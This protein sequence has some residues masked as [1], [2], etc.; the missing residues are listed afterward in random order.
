[1]ILALSADLPAP[2]FLLSLIRLDGVSSGPWYSA[3]IRPPSTLTSIFQYAPD[4]PKITPED[5][6]LVDYVTSATAKNMGKI[7][8][9]KPGKGSVKVKKVDEGGNPLL[10]SKFQLTRITKEGEKVEND[11]IYNG[12]SRNYNETITATIGAGQAKK[13]DDITI[14]PIAPGA[15]EIT[16]TTI[17]SSKVT[18]TLPDKSTIE[19]LSDTTGKFIAT[20]PDGVTLAADQKFLQILM[21]RE[22]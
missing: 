21:K 4:N 17:G 6:K 1:M 20:V 14:D 7:I 9:E 11:G 19:A 3:Y 15:K 13:G 10:G 8:N 18:I 16:G 5:G 12:E 2:A 22:L